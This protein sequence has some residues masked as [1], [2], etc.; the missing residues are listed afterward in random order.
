MKESFINSNWVT[1]VDSILIQNVP[2]RLT[3]SNLSAKVRPAEMFYNTATE[4][5]ISTSSIDHYLDRLKE[6]MGVAWDD[7]LTQ[8]ARVLFTTARAV[9]TIV[10]AGKFVGGAM[11]LGRSKLSLVIDQLCEQWDMA[12]GK[13]DKAV[14]SWLPEVLDDS[15]IK[16]LSNE[17]NYEG[18]DYSSAD[19]TN[20]AE[21]PN[22]KRRMHKCTPTTIA[23][24][25]GTRVL[26]RARAIASIPSQT[27]TSFSTQFKELL[28]Q[29]SWFTYVDSILMNNPVMKALASTF[30]PPSNLITNDS[31][32]ST[33]NT[34]LNNISPAAEHFYQTWL[35]HFK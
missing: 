1:I 9:T 6:R 24:K 21:T 28:I 35:D 4:V 23:N 18:L 34:S 25:V 32:N 11:Q 8:P 16:L 17:K 14:D 12:L 27:A 30:R 5:Y 2:I 10:G 29:K 7:R 31:P 22:K 3:I 19:D 20:G 33:I 13:A 15:E 26:Q